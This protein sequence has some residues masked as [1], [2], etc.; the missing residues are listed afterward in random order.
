MGVSRNVSETDGDFGHINFG[1]LPNL[2]VSKVPLTEFALE[3]F[4]VT[5][6]T[7]GN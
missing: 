7:V 6:I 5:A 2:F 1:N 3:F 4:F